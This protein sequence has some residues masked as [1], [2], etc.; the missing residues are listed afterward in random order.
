VANGRKGATVWPLPSRVGWASATAALS[1]DWDKRDTTVYGSFMEE[2]NEI[3][4]LLAED[5][6]LDAD[7]TVLTLR[8]IGVA[9]KLLRVRDGRE[10]LTFVFRQGKFA[11]R[12]DLLPKLILLDLHMP[13]AGGIEVLRQ[14]RE[15]S[16]TKDIPVVILTVSV[17]PTDFF[18]SQKLLVWDY[19]MK[20]VTR[21]AL[22][23]LVKQSGLMSPAAPCL[24]ASP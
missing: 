6:D 1:A 7:L 9:S 5:N 11:D 4:I 24:Q 23:D 13:M 22:V 2:W 18:E 8:R 15:C 14:L 10:A 17:D 20:P 12:D 19:L 16:I 3:E 21:E